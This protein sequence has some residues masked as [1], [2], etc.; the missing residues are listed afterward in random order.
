VFVEGKKQQQNGCTESVMSYAKKEKKKKKK[1]RSS[2][3][4]RPDKMTINAVANKHHH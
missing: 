3:D 1:S 2:L 4:E